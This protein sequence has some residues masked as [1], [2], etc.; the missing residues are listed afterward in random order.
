MS[1]PTLT[2]RLDAIV[3][4]RLRDV[5]FDIHKNRTYAKLYSIDEEMEI[6]ATLEYVLSAIRDRGF[7]VDGVTIQSNGTVTLDAYA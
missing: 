4:H 5:E 6:S 7:V 1:E 3:T 2:P